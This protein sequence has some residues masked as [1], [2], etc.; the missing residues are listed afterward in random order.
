MDVGPWS[1]EKLECLRKYLDA[2]TTILRKQNFKGYFYVDAF[3][4]PGSLTVRKS[5]A[6]NVTQ[7][8]L[9]EVA[10]H[11]AA[12]P[13]A[14]AYIDGSPRVALGIEHPFTDYVFVEVDPERIAQ[15][16]KLKGEFPSKRIHIRSGECAAY[17]EGLLERNR[18][19][20]RQWRGVVFLDPFGMQV[21]WRTI[22]ALG[23]T[24][25]I[26]VFLNFPVGM[27]IQRLLKRSG[28]FSAKERSKLDS[29]FG[30]SEWYDLLYRR[31][32]DLLGGTIE[33]I[34]ASGDALVKWYRARLKT[35]FGHV[36]AA[37]EVQ[38]TRGRALYY[39][40]FSGPNKTGAGIAND[41][42]RQGARVVR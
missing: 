15:L 1:R 9:F 18:G 28:E 36:S 42:L 32:T 25:A 35:V 8:S 20:W 6:K 29:Y 13:E 19:R 40:I 37:R 14:A 11:Y 33:K 26:E 2:Y 7:Q 21:P 31:E 39:L 24:R 38:N 41:V 10:E 17:L 4:G 12:D 27:A 22:A 30:S 34:D 3:A 5:R 23:K 16:E